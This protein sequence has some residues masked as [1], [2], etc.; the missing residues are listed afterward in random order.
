LQLLVF[1]LGFCFLQ[2]KPLVKPHAE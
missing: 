1:S 2:S